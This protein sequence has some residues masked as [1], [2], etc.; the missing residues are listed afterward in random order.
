MLPNGSWSGIKSN[1]PSF[2]HQPHQKPRLNLK[3]YL[4]TKSDKC[5]KL[6]E[7]MCPIITYPRITIV[8]PSFN[9]ERYLEATIRSVLG[10]SYPN[11]DY[12]I[13][14]GGSTDCSVEIIKKYKEYLSY[15]C[16]E[17]DSGMY[18]ALRKGFS[19]SNGQIMGWINSDDL[20]FPWT[21][22]TLAEA[23]TIFPKVEWLSSLYPCAFNSNGT[24]FKSGFKAGYSRKYFQNG[25][26]MTIPNRQCFGFIQQESTFWKRSLY[27]RAGGICADYRF[28]GDFDLWARFFEQSELYGIGCMLGGFRYH[29]ADQLSNKYFDLY[30]D[31]AYESLHQVGG[32]VCTPLKGWLLINH[33]K[34]M[35]KWP[36]FKCPSLGLLQLVHNIRWDREI[37][38]WAITDNWI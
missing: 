16:S 13:I 37:N 24:L 18:D 35:S 26:Y 6:S 5:F 34:I 31:E 29:D 33:T 8:T 20:L 1:K 27:D 10:Q 4:A 2:A 38:G 17:P 25:L 12:I 23:F 7:C 3:R 32:A 30:F 19:R 22:H 11:L 14:D 28:A 21:L 36:R 9:S 15:W